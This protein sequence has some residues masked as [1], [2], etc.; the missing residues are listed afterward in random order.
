MLY[1]CSV[2]SNAEQRQNLYGQVR[3]APR[4]DAIKGADLAQAVWL[5]SFTVFAFGLETAVRSIRRNGLC[6]RGTWETW[7]T[8]G[9]ITLLTLMMWLSSFLLPADDSCIGS[10]VWWTEN[11]ALIAIVLIPVIILVN[12]VTSTIII[13]QLLRTTK[14][15]RKER[16]MASRVVYTIILSIVLL[17]S[18][19]SSLTVDALLSQIRLYCYHTT[20]RSLRIG[21]LTALPTQLLLRHRILPTSR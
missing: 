12:S 21:S 18:H 3:T 16:I 4:C 15:D 9:F 11:Y 6:A 8:V 14:V 17:V 2:S 10:L 5:F 1:R 13:I 19:L 20:L 7:L